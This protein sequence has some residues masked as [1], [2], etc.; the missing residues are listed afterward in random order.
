M[1]IFKVTSENII[2]HIEEFDEISK[3]F[4]LDAEEIDRLKA[5]MIDY[6]LV[7][8]ANELSEEFRCIIAARKL[9][10]IPKLTTE[11]VD[12]ARLAFESGR[13]PF[14]RQDV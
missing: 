14:V 7:D 5:V 13:I 12:R 4:L 6:P 8:I 11:T 2:L 10:A 3:Y 1:T 9:A